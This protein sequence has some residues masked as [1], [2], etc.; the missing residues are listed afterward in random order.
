[1]PITAL[2]TPPSRN[3]PTNFATRAD[4]FLAALPTFATEASALQADVNSKQ[5]LAT[6]SASA[7]VAAQAAAAATANTTQWVSGTTYAL[8]ATVWSPITYSSYRRKIAGAGT[9]DPSVDTTNWIKISGTG[10]VEADGVGTAGQV[11]ISQGVGLPAT[12]TNVQSVQ[13]FASSGTWTKP[14][15]ASVVMVELWGAGGG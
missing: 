11:L 12:F 15:G 1:M 10:N 13:A 5:S 7:A 4:A 8:G 14:S 3:D 2:P 6:N 9:T